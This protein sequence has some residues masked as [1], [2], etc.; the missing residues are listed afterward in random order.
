MV[1]S[2]L[3]GLLETPLLSNLLILFWISSVFILLMRIFSL[4]FRYLTAYSKS[5]WLLE[6]QKSF[7]SNEKV[8]ISRR[9]AFRIFY[10]TGLIVCSVRLLLSRNPCQHTVLHIYMYHLLRRLY[11]SICIHR[12]SRSTVSVF[13]CF[14][15][16]LFYVFTPLTLPVRNFPVIEQVRYTLGVLRIILFIIVSWL[17]FRIHGHLS[18]L[19][20]KKETEGYFLPSF[21][22]ILFPHYTAEIIL[23][24][25]FCSYAQSMNDLLMFSIPLLFTTLNLSITSF[26]QRKY[27]EQYFQGM[28]IP[29]YN[30]VPYLF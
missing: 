9:V 30:I 29:K 8:E 25:L 15:G 28:K 11:E 14:G 21:T 19:R 3:L 6:K 23:Y 4:S 2:L 13:A 1:A 16:T 20:S 26:E 5:K 18:S 12:F 17:Q 27:Y 24:T 10:S 22:T 7:V